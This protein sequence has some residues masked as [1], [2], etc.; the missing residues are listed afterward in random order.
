MTMNLPRLTLAA[1]CLGT[2]AELASAQA[3]MENRY[4]PADAQPWYREAPDIPAE[5]APLWGDRARGEA[6]TLLRTPSGFRSGLHSHTADYWALVVQGTWQHW[7]PS[8]GEG[9]GLTLLPGSFWT[10]KHTQLH[11]D[12]CISQEPCVIFLFNKEPYVTEFPKS[13]GGGK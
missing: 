7:V 6:G 11:E 10:Q 13:A 12:A 4:V 8:T 3:T 5:L 9:K 2:C 1:L